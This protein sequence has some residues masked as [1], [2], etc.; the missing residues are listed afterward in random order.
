MTKGC[1]MLTN[2]GLE[3]FDGKWKDYLVINRFPEIVVAEDQLH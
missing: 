3:R 1:H 2:Y